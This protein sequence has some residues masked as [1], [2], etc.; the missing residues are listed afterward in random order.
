MGYLTHYKGSDRESM[1]TGEHAPKKSFFD[2]ARGWFSKAKDIGSKILKNPMVYGLATH[3]YDYAKKRFPQYGGMI[4]K[5]QGMHK[6]YVDK[7]QNGYNHG[8]KPKRPAYS[9]MQGPPPKK[10]TFPGQQAFKQVTQARQYD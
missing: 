10:K 5:A 4:N 8:P 6:K 2:K 1:A 3:A 7:Q 9:S